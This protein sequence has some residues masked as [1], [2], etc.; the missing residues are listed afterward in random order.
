MIYRYVEMPDNVELYVN[1]TEDGLIHF[2]IGGADACS[3]NLPREVATDLAREILK[4]TA[5]D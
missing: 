3:I 1:I 5:D 4:E 2:Y